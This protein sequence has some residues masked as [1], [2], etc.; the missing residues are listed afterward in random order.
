MTVGKPTRR[1]FIA[2]SA[3][4]LGS[5]ALSQDAQ[6][7]EKSGRARVVQVEHPGATT[8]KT[9]LDDDVVKRM[10]SEALKAYA[11]TDTA[12]A[13]LAKYFKK[14]EKIAIKINTLGSPYSSVNPIVAFTLAELLVEMGASRDNVRIFDQYQS[15]MR[16]GR[17]RLRRKEGEVWVTQHMG[18]TEELQTYLEPEEFGTPGKKQKKV[19]FHWEELIG[20]ADSV[21]NLCIPK[22]H[23]LTGVTGALKNM[24]MGVVKPTEAYYNRKA[25]NPGH[26]T[27][28]P[29]FHKN[30]CNPAIAWL[31]S[32]PMIKG[33]V[34][35]VVADALR[36]LYHGGPQ[37]KPQYR[38]LNNQIWVTEDPV[39]ND[40]LILQLV[41]GI[42]K[43]KGMKPVE[44]DLWRGKPRRPDYIKTCAAYGLGIADLKRIDVEKKVLS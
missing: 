39:A 12:T 26:Y 19:E 29:R 35:L 13:A 20:W 34:R 21:L 27:I 43:D 22:D 14:D 18:R 32:Q 5:S 1:G 37:D 9:S 2:G 36:V 31:Y 30:N 10:I 17:Y 8:G 11:K 23:D 41:N 38:Q 33:K 3:A 40:A 7:K 28:V 6:S 44:E 42:R 15:R 24:A 25:G 4:L 16:K